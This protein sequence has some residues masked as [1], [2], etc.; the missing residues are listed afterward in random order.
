M[1]VT[2]TV[3]R[4]ARPRIFSMPYVVAVAHPMLCFVSLLPI[5]CGSKL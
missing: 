4:Q 5:T 3:V 2:R 1:S